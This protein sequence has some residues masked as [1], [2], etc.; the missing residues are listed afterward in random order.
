MAVFMQKITQFIFLLV[1]T[2][3]RPAEVIF[4]SVGVQFLFKV[5]QI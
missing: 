5:N 3:Q 1:T 4:S 2:N